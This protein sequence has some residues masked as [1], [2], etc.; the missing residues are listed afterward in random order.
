MLICGALAL[1][2]VAA[3]VDGD[4][5]MWLFNDLPVDHLKRQHGFEP[6]E[7]WAR[8]VMLS[9]VRFNSGG[10]ASFVSSS[11]LVLTNH[12]VA[13]DT[14]QKISTPEHNYMRDG[15]LAKSHAE[16]V[17]APDLEL[18][19]LVSIDDVTQRVNVAVPDG[20]SPAEAFKARC[21]VMAEIEKES[22]D[23]TGLRSDVVTLYGGAKYH[24]YRYKKYTDVRLVWAPETAAAFFGGDADNFEYPRYCLDVALFRVYEDNKPAQIKHFLKYSEAGATDGELVFVSG[25]P[26][27]TQ[28]IFTVAA[29]K[30]LRDARMPY[31]LNLLRRL[32]IL[33]Q[34]YGYEG[35]EQQRRA[36]DE[37]FGIQNVR[38]AY[39][40]MLQGLQTPALMQLKQAQEERLLDQLQSNPQLADYSAAWQI[41]ADAQKRRVQ[42]LGQSASFA[43]NSHHYDIA[44][45]LNLMAAE[46]Q[47]PSEDRLREYRDSARESLEQQLYSPAPI[48]DDLEIVKLADGLALFVEQRGGDDPLV[49]QVLA[50][51]SPR[52]LRRGTGRADG[53]GRCRNPSST[54]RRRTSCHRRFDRSHAETGQTTGTR[55]SSA[56]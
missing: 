7:D 9:S 45:T 55:I 35:D 42:L 14:L 54:G 3:R 56:A 18:N 38:K 28:R 40:G 47:K 21:A 15:F 10:S 17:K 5:G 43:R 23:S 26:G 41:I 32:E 53:A 2:L 30:Y 4:E 8:H 6:T 13:S 34:Q 31:V 44:E 11:G 39:T 51:K 20:L 1:S 36:R 12:H 50:G 16:E 29:L 37:L 19:Q 46:D 25:N 24:L 33:L 52:E 48:Y 22:L 27:R 49:Q